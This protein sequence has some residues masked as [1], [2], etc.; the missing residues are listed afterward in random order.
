MAAQEEEQSME[1]ILQSI[2]KII[3]EDEDEIEVPEQEPEGLEALE[4]S[5]EI[6]VADM[7]ADPVAE[8]KPTA[9]EEP[10]IVAQ[11]DVDAMFDSADEEPQEAA[12]EEIAEALEEDDDVLELT[13]EITEDIADADIEEIPEIIEEPIEEIAAQPAETSKPKAAEAGAVDALLSNEAA[14]KAASAL[15]QLKQPAAAPT[16]EKLSFRSG[17]TVEDLVLEALRPMLKEWLNSELPATVERMVAEEIK[18]ISN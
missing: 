18:R 15:A 13:D 2:K 5:E 17:A 9:D 12:L 8:E 11:D 10:E 1:E 14:S 4:A 16:G 3:A 6:E 7:N